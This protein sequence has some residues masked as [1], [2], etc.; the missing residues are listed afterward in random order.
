MIKQAAN[1][2]DSSGK[3]LPTTFVFGGISNII[4]PTNI[5]IE[6]NNC[7]DI[8]NCDVDA[9]ASIQRRK[10]FQRTFIH[11]SLPVGY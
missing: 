8:I 4:D 10:G 6:S 2:K 7:V 9:S 5:T 11:R 3:L 1:Q